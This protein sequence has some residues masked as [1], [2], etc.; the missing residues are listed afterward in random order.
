MKAASLSADDMWN[1][2]T[3]NAIVLQPSALADTSTRGRMASVSLRCCD[4]NFNSHG[5]VATTYV[6]SA[7]VART[8]ARHAVMLLPVEV[9][10]FAVHD[11]RRGREFHST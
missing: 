3:H 8:D 1:A 7:S 6:A 11:G 2:F 4:D 5:S 10:S 9:K